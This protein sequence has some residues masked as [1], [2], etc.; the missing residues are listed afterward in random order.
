MRVACLISPESQHSTGSFEWMANQLKSIGIW[1]ARVIV[2]DLDD[3]SNNTDL[4]GRLVVELPK[5]SLSKIERIEESIIPA[6]LSVLFVEMNNP[7]KTKKH[8]Y[9]KELSSKKLRIIISSLQDRV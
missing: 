7:L 8:T 5:T 1:R 2:M 3:T 4:I 6:G 9:Y